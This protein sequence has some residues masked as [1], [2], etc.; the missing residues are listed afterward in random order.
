MEKD[1]TVTVPKGT[2]WETMFRLERE[3]E[4][5]FAGW[6]VWVSGPDHELSEPHIRVD[7]EWSDDPKIEKKV[8]KAFDRASKWRE[9]YSIVVETHPFQ[10]GYLSKVDQGEPFTEFLARL[11]ETLEERGY[12]A[13][14]LRSEMNE[15]DVTIKPVPDDGLREIIEGEINGAWEAADIVP[16]SE[17]PYDEDDEDDEDDDD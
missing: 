9:D 15:T 4:S 14:A 6:E 12:N 3:L 5:E 11:E 10:I 17:D 8:D 7:G 16:P 1:L 2:D 13:S